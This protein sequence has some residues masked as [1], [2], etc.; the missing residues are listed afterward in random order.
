MEEDM[1]KMMNQLKDGEIDKAIKS[2]E[3]ILSKY[4][5][6]DEQYKPIYTKYTEF[7][8]WLEFEEDK[9]KISE[10]V[11]KIISLE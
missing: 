8:E 2:R 7:F 1:L 11:D 3:I 9:K 4:D 6:E 10:M 5:K